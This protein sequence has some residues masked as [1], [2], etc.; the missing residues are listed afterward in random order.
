METEVYYGDGGKV[1]IQNVKSECAAIQGTKVFVFLP[2]S[3]HSG[4]LL[5]GGICE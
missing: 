5:S 1:L 4:I 3:D 2:R